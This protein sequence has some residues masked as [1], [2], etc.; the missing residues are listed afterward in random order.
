M[1][2]SFDNPS[3]VDSALERSR[4][5]LQ[6]FEQA[7]DR[8]RLLERLHSASPAHPVLLARAAFM[9]FT[10]TTAVLA[11]LAILAPF[12]LSALAAGGQRWASEVNR[13]LANFDTVVPVPTGVPGV[14][15]LFVVVAICMLVGWVTTTFAALA[16]GRETRLMPWEAREHQRL[17]NEITQLSAQRAG[18]AR[19]THVSP[20]HSLRSFGSDV[21][22][23]KHDLQRT[24][25]PLGSPPWGTVGLHPESDTLRT[26]RAHYGAGRLG[27]VPTPADGGAA[28]TGRGGAPLHPEGR[29]SMVSDTPR[30]GQ[31]FLPAGAREDAEPHLSARHSL[32][33]EPLPSATRHRQPHAAPVVA[34]ACRAPVG[35]VQDPSH[36]VACRVPG[37]C[38]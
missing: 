19:A 8:K 31:S 38:H 16:I 7:V 3:E 33:I 5:Q 30:H 14:P 9:V 1:I 26:G 35:Q 24:R 11:I 37:A 28:P 4:A 17:V 22:G 20:H 2:Q 32:P 13:T 34:A 6:A 25:P 36:S 21:S 18:M 15:A 29:H 27:G 23:P 12:I 10:G